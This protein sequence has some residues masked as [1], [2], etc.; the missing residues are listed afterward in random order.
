MFLFCHDCIQ[1]I[2]AE[3]S[4][5]ER[6][7][8]YGLRRR[9]LVMAKVQEQLGS[10]SGMIESTSFTKIHSFLSTSCTKAKVR[11]FVT[12]LHRLGLIV[13]NKEDHSWVY[14]L[15]QQG[16]EIVNIIESNESDKAEIMRILK[17]SMKDASTKG[18]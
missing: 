9:E 12:F 4:S 15:S 7:I 1:K 3:L 8:L 14:A 2:Y 13:R 17:T 10:P 6:A 5:Y 16:E 18:D 11:Q